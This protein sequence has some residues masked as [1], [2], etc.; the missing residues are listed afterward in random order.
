MVVGERLRLA[1]TR[2]SGPRSSVELGRAQPFFREPNGNTPEHTSTSHTQNEYAYPDFPIDSLSP[3]N[4][5]IGPRSSSHNV[6][7]RQKVTAC[8]AGRPPNFELTS[9]TPDL[10]QHD[11]KDDQAHKACYNERCCMF[12]SVC[13]SLFNDPD[14]SG[15]VEQG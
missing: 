14:S 10:L 6:G 9:P 5:R 1:V 12:C 8:A 3:F 2:G 11:R 7:Q 4:V 13:R 15:V